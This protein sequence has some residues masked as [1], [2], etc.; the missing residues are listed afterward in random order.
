[1]EKL[2]LKKEMT[3]QSNKNKTNN[4]VLKENERLD[5]L[6][7]NNLHII[8]NKKLYCFSSDAVLLCNFVKAKKTDTI[9]DLC[10]GSGVVGILAQAKT[11]AKQLYMIEL[12]EE[13]ADMCNHS[14]I[15]NGLQNKAKVFCHDVVNAQNVLFEETGKKQFDVVCANPPYYLTS[16]KKLSGKESIDIA[17]FE[18]RLNL[19]S[20]CKNASDLL[21]Y[22]GKF[23]MINDS[24]RIAEIIETLKKYNLEPKVLEFVFSKKNEKSNVVLIEAE[25]LGKSGVK[26]LYK[27]LY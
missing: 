7:F 9:V 17:K 21:K 25:K 22:G 26:V 14:I 2:S 19:N 27:N 8:Q 1:M 20:L 3:S 15:Y 23:Y 4:I 18:L 10:S 6:Q 16:Q 5:D 11:N 13:L 12:Q 24:E